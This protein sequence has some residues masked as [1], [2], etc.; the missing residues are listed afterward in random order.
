MFKPKIIAFDMTKSAE[1]IPDAADLRGRLVGEIPE[2]EIPQLVDALRLFGFP[3][4]KRTLAQQLREGRV[5]QLL[6]AL[7][8]PGVLPGVRTLMQSATIAVCI[9]GSLEGSFTTPELQRAAIRFLRE[10][11]KRQ[12]D[13][14]ALKKLADSGVDGD[15]R[16]LT[17]EAIIKIGERE[18]GIG[19]VRG[20]LGSETWGEILT[21]AVRLIGEKGDKRDANSLE[22]LLTKSDIVN[23]KELVRQEAALALAKIGTS[24]SF[25]ALSRALDET[26]PNNVLGAVGEAIVAISFRE[27]EDKNA[28]L[29]QLMED[30]RYEVCRAAFKVMQQEGNT[31]DLSYLD[32]R[33]AREVNPQVE[34]QIAEAVVAIKRRAGD[35]EGIR[36]ELGP[37]T[38]TG[39][40]CRQRAAARVLAEEGNIQDIFA[41]SD[42]MV[43][44]GDL[45]VFGTAIAKIC[46][47]E[48]NVAELRALSEKDDT[49]YV[50]PSVPALLEPTVAFKIAIIDGLAEIGTRDEVDIL[51]G[52]LGFSDLRV[53]SAAATALGKLATST[54]I[55]KLRSLLAQERFEGCRE[56]I[57]SAMVEISIRDRGLDGSSDLLNQEHLQ[58]PYIR[59]V[60]EKGERVVHTRVLRDK[61]SQ[62]QRPEV[63]DELGRAIIKILAREERM[64]AIGLLLR[65]TD[66]E[67]I[68]V[69]MAA[70]ELV[71]EKEGKKEDLD[72]LA[73]LWSSDERAAP[74]AARAII[75]ICARRGCWEELIGLYVRGK[76]DP[77]IMA[78]VEQLEGEEEDA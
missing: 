1:G 16:R 19:W 3:L 39:L 51:E 59:L 74:I 36:A 45:A 76:D 47:R 35:I 9:R 77:L 54:S 57:A 73:Q 37:S 24:E 71:G 26:N 69:R 15:L 31:S 75:K 43:T 33:F 14:Q 52:L 4:V 29:R 55:S 63:R 42:R 7:Q 70:A 78:M 21:Q 32:E 34:K 49:M 25:P 22:S 2:A 10:G 50:G 5:D 20:V 72:A 48:R 23:D 58:I 64:L 17:G 61:L 68:E 8:K 40:E 53:V 30:R 62:E 11:G 38:E 67:P 65:D 46:V 13:I 18:F 28:T 66:G 41:L 27:A 12:N 56:A 44:V 60:G 6:A